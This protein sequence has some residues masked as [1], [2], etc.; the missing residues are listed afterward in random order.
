VASIR[1]HT[2][3]GPIGETWVRCEEESFE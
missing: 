3:E 2:A 1:Q